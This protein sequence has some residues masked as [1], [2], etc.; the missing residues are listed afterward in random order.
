MAQLD[1]RNFV[2]VNDRYSILPIRTDPGGID[3]DRFG[4]YLRYRDLPLLLIL[5]I[6]SDTTDGSIGK[7]R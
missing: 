5:P 4:K 3:S 1:D 7:Y 6:L 2:I